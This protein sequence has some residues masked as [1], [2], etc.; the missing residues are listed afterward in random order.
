[1]SSDEIAD[2][3]KRGK[4]EYSGENNPNAK[5]IVNITTGESFKTVKEACT[6][7]GLRQSSISNCLIGRN[8]SAGKSADGI[9]Y[10]WVYAD[11]YDTMS[12]KEICVKVDKAKNANKGR[13][14]PNARSVICITT[15]DIFS[16]A[17]DAA[18]TFHIDTSSLIKCCKGK[19]KHCGERN[20]EKLVWQYVS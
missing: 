11:E 5:S 20:G 13:N 8:L 10:V 6:T 18:N 2:R 16:N 9:P 15:G 3:L 1:M 17:T 4:I 14:K 19:I 7:L 12:K